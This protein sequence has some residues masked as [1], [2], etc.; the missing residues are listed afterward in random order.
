MAQG[1]PKRSQKVRRMRKKCNDG[2]LE[3]YQK[4]IAISLRIALRRLR[5]PPAGSQLSAFVV[6]Q[7]I[8]AGGRNAPGFHSAAGSNSG[9]SRAVGTPW[10]RPTRRPREPRC[11]QE[12]SQMA[13]GWPKG[14]QKVRR[15]KKNCN[16]GVLEK[17]QKTIGD[18]N[19]E[20]VMFLKTFKNHMFL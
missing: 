9:A 14:S 20:K 16:H 17:H 11:L 10:R 15:R 19:V 1:W 6:V 18:G 8:C 12:G 13:Q 4:T 3:K 5:E 2:V 7:E